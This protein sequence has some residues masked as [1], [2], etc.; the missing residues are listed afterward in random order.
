MGSLSGYFGECE[1]VRFI[2]AG[3]DSKWRFEKSYLH[4]LFTVSVMIFVISLLQKSC[5]NS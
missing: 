3:F 1:E 2:Q 5:N 4:H